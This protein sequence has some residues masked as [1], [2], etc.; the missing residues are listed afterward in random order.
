MSSG[1]PLFENRERVGHPGIN[2]CNGDVTTKVIC[3]FHSR[4]LALLLVHSRHARSD[5]DQTKSSAM[6]EEAFDAP[7]GLRTV[8]SYHNRVCLLEI[9]TVVAYF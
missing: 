1:I 5:A 3:P 2:E 6:V 9:G 7:S 4:K 8:G